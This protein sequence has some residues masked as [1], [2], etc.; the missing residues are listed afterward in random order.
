M[1]KVKKIDFKINEMPF[2]FTVSTTIE[3]LKE[4][5]HNTLFAQ[6]SLIDYHFSLL[7]NNSEPLLLN[8]YHD[9][10]S[11]QNMLLKSGSQIIVEHSKHVGNNNLLTTTCSSTSRT[12]TIIN[13]L[14]DQQQ[15][16]ELTVNS[17][18]HVDEIKVRAMSLFDNDYDL[19]AC[20]LR[21]LT[22]EEDAAGLLSGVALHSEQTLDEAVNEYVKDSNARL[23]VMLCQGRAPS[24]LANEISLR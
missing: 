5:V 9:K 12:L 8:V 22:D 16:Q 18:E 24:T 2:T 17:D 6:N 15:Q 23:M 20:H 4:T 13:C 19:N 10:K 11:L 7:R 21:V 1:L 14:L 3:Q